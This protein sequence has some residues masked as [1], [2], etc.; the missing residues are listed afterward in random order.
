MPKTGNPFK[1]DYDPELDTSLDFDPDA[2]SLYLT[3]IG[4]LR[5]MIE[6]G[7]IYIVTEVLLLSSHMVLPGEG[8]LEA[9]GNVMAQVGQKYNS[10]LLY[11]PLHPE[12]DH[13]V[14]KEYYW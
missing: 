8:H 13:C 6:F 10:R 12:T 7:I 5:W 1:M 4:I 9:A 2:T 11:D 3:I 14:V